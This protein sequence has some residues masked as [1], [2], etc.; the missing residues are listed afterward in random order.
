MSSVLEPV[1]TSEFP[2]GGKA[3]YI[4]GAGIAKHQV[5]FDPLSGDMSAVP[6][7][8][9][10]YSGK[11]YRF[12]FDPV[13]GG[14]EGQA[15]IAD[16]DVTQG[17][18]L[19]EVPSREELAGMLPV[20]GQDALPTTKT[21][22]ALRSQ[23][24]WQMTNNDLRVLATVIRDSKTHF[25]G[26]LHETAHK[27]LANVLAHELKALPGEAFDYLQIVS[28]TSRW[29]QWLPMMPES[30]EM[31][32]AVIAQRKAR[33]TFTPEWYRSVGGTLVEGDVVSP[34]APAVPAVRSVTIGV[35]DLP[36]AAPRPQSAPV[37]KVKFIRSD[38]ID[39]NEPFTR[40]TRIYGQLMAS[41]G[42]QL[43]R[44]I[45]EAAVGRASQADMLELSRLLLPP[46]LPSYRLA[47]DYRQFPATKEWSPRDVRTHFAGR[48]TH[49][50]TQLQADGKFDDADKPAAMALYKRI[51]RHQPAP[52]QFGTALPPV[53][54]EFDL[55]R[56]EGG[57]RS[58]G[59]MQEIDRLHRDA[60]DNKPVLAIAKLASEILSQEAFH[61]FSGVALRPENTRLSLDDLALR[62]G[63]DRDAAVSLFNG[64]AKIVRE[65]VLTLAD[66]PAFT[67]R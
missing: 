25:R 61:A 1:S 62:L 23:F 14:R 5:T 7:A 35:P 21:V 36:K 67:P 15:H 12:G 28:A 37:G 20:L 48:L 27:P 66:N 9:R 31:M 45:V 19:H 33:L 30:R 18:H 26:G 32:K 64:A 51:H 57:R 41:V 42:S 13:Y 50:L 38:A 17:K 6:K 49:W 10:K 24:L 65:S 44:K 59:V 56:K 55:K 53:A 40:A 58:T 34:P 22:D 2:L 43:E 4:S 39:A 16:S 11:I 29:P 8:Y 60:P 54:R 52:E 47:E 63:V 46:E 3:Y